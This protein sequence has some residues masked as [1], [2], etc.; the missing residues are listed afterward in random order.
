MKKDLILWLHRNRNR[1]DECL[2]VEVPT[3][4]GFSLDYNEI[5]LSIFHEAKD[6]ERRLK[7]KL[8]LLYQISDVL[9]IK[10]LTVVKE[11]VEYSEGKKIC[12]EIPEAECLD[13]LVKSCY[14]MEVVFAVEASLNDEEIKQHLTNVEGL[15]R[16]QDNYPISIGEI[17]SY[18]TSP[19]FIFENRLNTDEVELMLRFCD[20]LPSV[21]AENKE[22]YKAISG[23]NA[24]NHFSTDTSIPND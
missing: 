21:I 12:V 18:L 17:S 10:V 6:P 16:L 9:L 20:Y 23:E 1:I 4:V 19:R 15:G 13:I 5:L 2:R 24:R 7:E 22:E 3:L 14:A 8:G 11:V